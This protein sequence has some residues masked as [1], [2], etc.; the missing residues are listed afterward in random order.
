MKNLFL[1]IALLLVSAEAFPQKNFHSRDAGASGGAN[2]NYNLYLRTIDIDEKAM[3]FGLTETEFNKIKDEA[4][5]NPN[6]VLGKIFQDDQLLRSDVPMRYNAY[7]DEIEIKKSPR[8]KSFGA[9]IKDPNIFAKI[10]ADIYV[11]IPFEESIEKGGYFSVMAEGK[12]YD[13]YKKT[14]AVFKERQKAATNFATDI[15]PSFPKVVTYYLVEDGKFLE[16]PNSKSRILKM[17]DIK[18]MEMQEFI[19]E[20]RIDLDKESDLVKAVIYFDSLL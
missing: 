20:N 15:P 6:F 10:G 7:A 9:L 12:K 1:F 8:D 4:Y 18:K 14:T 3:S 16:M 5:P 2:S 13:L 11:F 17:M 19:K